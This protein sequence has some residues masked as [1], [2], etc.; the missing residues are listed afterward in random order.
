MAVLKSTSLASRGG[1][2]AAAAGRTLL[3]CVQRPGDVL[4]V[5]DF[6]GHAVLNEAPSVG[7]ASEF[8]T[9]RMNFAFVG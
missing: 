7:V 2:R 3:R 5:P 1:R 4:F 6:W 9:A 8:E